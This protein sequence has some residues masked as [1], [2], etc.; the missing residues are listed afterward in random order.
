MGGVCVRVCAR[1]HVCE[2]VCVHVCVIVY[3]YEMHKC[4]VVCV[5]LCVHIHCVAYLHVSILVSCVF[6]AS[7]TTQQHRTK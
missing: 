1:M 3:M 7:H 6:C 5:S 2:C 4:C